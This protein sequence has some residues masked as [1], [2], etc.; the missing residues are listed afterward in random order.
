[1]FWHS[2]RPLILFHQQLL[3]FRTVSGHVT[4]SLLYILVSLQHIHCTGKLT[5][6]IESLCFHQRS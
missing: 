1:M 5:G 6:Y 4:L 3:E 2:H